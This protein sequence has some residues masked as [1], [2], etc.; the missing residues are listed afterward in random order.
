MDFRTIRIPGRQKCWQLYLYPVHLSILRLSAHLELD[1]LHLALW[2]SVSQSVK[3][4]YK[5]WWQWNFEMQ[6]ILQGKTRTPFEV[7][8]PCHLYDNCCIELFYYHF[9]QNPYKN[10]VLES[11]QPNQILHTIQSIGSF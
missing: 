7:G 6:T 1:N 4:H 10:M 2:P 11:S 5:L 9:G 3:I 8:R